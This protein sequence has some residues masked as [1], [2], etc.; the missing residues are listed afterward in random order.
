MGQCRAA[1]MTASAMPAHQIES[2]EPVLSKATPPS[3][4]PRKAPTWWLKKT[5]PKSVPRFRVP[6]ITATSPEVSGTVESHRTP[7]ARRR[8]AR[9]SASA[10]G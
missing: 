2:K 8:G 10:A 4:T 5:I 1:A 7:I 9:P 6:N 3:Q